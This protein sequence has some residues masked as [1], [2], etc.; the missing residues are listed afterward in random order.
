MNMKKILVI[1]LFCGVA[2]WPLACGKN[3]SPTSQ[4]APSSTPTLT[5]TS[6][7]AP[8]WNITGA[9]TLTT[10]SYNYGNIHIYN[11][12]SLQLMGPSGA[13]TGAAVTLNLTGDFAMDAGASVIGNYTGYGPGQGP[14][15]GGVYFAN[16]GGGGHGGAGG[17]GG[18]AAAGP[19]NDDPL[20]PILMGSGGGSAGGGGAGGALLRINAVSASL[21]GAILVNGN[22]VPGGGGGAGGTIFI[23]ANTIFGNGTLQ[24]E[25]GGAI[26][27]FTGGG[28]GGI[29]TLSV[30][31]GYYFT[32][33]IGVIGESGG[34]PNSTGANGYFE[35]TGF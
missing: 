16:A 34:S 21:N 14:G 5:A 9:V 8:D 26:T 4:A 31:D 27:P 32:G 30:H 20:G 11:G 29:I 12:G 24:A 35:Q 2:L 28:G 22:L 33:A 18:S 10:G 25:G 23:Q 15:A 19:A 1:G 3:V 17:A 13:V 7:P 6:T